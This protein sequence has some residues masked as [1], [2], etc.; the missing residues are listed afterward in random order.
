GGAGGGRRWRRWKQGGGVWVGGGRGRCRDGSAEGGDCC[1]QRRRGRGVAWADYD[2]DGRRDLAVSHNA[3]PAV[4]LANRTATG[5]NWLR[6]ELVSDGQKS[7]RN[8]IGARVEVEV[9]EQ[10]SPVK[11]VHF[12]TGGGSYLSASERR[13]LIGLGKA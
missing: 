5:N 1:R 2:N 7:N 13:L 4:L 9:S 11:Q 8:A 12:L 10:R 6:L 3:G